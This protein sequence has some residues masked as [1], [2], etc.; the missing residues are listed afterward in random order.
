MREAC[1]LEIT[2]NFSLKLLFGTDFEKS[3]STGEQYV[4]FV[5]GIFRRHVSSVAA[6]HAVID[7]P[8][9]TLLWIYCQRHRLGSNDNV[10]DKQLKSLFATRAALTSDTKDSKG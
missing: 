2:A 7:D 6:R 4:A 3:Q 9:A 10:S 8:T 5:T 1:D